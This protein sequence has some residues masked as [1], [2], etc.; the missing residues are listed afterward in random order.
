MFQIWYHLKMFLPLTL[1]YLAARK[2]LQNIL[3]L[4]GTLNDALQIHAK[5]LTS[6]TLSGKKCG[7][8]KFADGRLN[9]TYPQI[10]YHQEIN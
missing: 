5:K 10:W 3:Y 6:C 7:K 4:L 9:L 1:K 8:L 2:L